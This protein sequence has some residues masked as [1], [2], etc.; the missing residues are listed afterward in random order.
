MNRQGRAN[1]FAVIACTPAA[2]V[3]PRRVDKEPATAFSLAA[4]ESFKGVGPQKFEDHQG[5][6][7]L[8]GSYVRDSNAPPQRQWGRQ[9]CG[10]DCLAKSVA[11]PFKVGVLQWTF[12]E[13]AVENPD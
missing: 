13:V 4:T 12:F 11:N 6:R 5:H 1:G 7:V 10:V 3:S 8:D 9:M 2:T